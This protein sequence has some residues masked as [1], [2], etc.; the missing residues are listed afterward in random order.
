MLA[1]VNIILMLEELGWG[2]GEESTCPVTGPGNP[3]LEKDKVFAFWE[4]RG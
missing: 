1:G 4:L 2:R 3:G